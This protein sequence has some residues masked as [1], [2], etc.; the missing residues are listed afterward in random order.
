MK[1]LKN[2]SIKSK[3]WI[4]V[5]TTIMGF[6]SNIV[7]VLILFSNLVNKYNTNHDN[8]LPSLE[9][10]KSVLITGS[11]VGLIFFIIFTYVMVKSITDSV[12]DLSEISIDLA[13]GSSDLKK[14]IVVESKDEISYL[15]KNINNFISKIHDTVKIAKLT[16]NQNK[17]VADEFLEISS[18]MKSRISKEFGI[19]EETKN[20]GDLVKE[21]L[22]KVTTDSKTTSEEII[23]TSKSLNNTTN[24]I[25][26]LVNNIQYASQVE[27]ESSQK[28]EQLNSETEQVKNILEVIGDIADQTNLLALNAAIEAARAGEH[29]RGFAVVA[30]E[31]RKLAERTQHSLSEI[32]MAINI[33][34]QGVSNASE[35]MN[36][37]FK[38]IE[39][40]VEASNRVKEDILHTQEIMNKTSSISLN[41]A[42]ITNNLTKDIEK[43]LNKID[44]ILEYSTQNNQC[45]IKLSKKTE[46][47]QEHTNTVTS[48]L[49]EFQV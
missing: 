37:N 7:L 12:D 23:S 24:E 8:L 13:K 6:T 40:L 39:E 3:G 18:Q 1:L 27:A 29:G 17:D 26:Q 41:S 20:I 10:S 42:N 43:I 4:L 9:F 47:L 32:D 45:A 16:S 2:I 14:R 15:S 5:G 25:K 49:N 38:F 44:A 21:S 11:I 30:D 48:K 34:V 36:K 46:E 31:V 33:I 22:E 19:V 35:Q 28:I